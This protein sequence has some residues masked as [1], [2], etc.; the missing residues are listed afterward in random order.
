MKNCL[1]LE[2]RMLG[3]RFAMPDVCR[4]AKLIWHDIPQDV[5]DLYDNLALQAQ[6]LHSEMFPNYKFSP[7]KRTTFKPYVP[8]QED[9]GLCMSTFTVNEFFK[10]IHT[11]VPSSPTPLSP[12][13][14]NS[15]SP[16]PEQPFLQNDPFLVDPCLPEDNLFF[17]GVNI[18]P[19]LDRYFREF[20]ECSIGYYLNSFIKS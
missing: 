18:S 8:V 14:P 10:E 4:Q 12:L 16:N 11:S 15:D 1:M 20:E 2:L 13:S 7:K 6:H 9:Q 3:Y 17:P 19:E 5:K